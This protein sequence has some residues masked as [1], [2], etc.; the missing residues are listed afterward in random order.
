MQSGLKHGYTRLFPTFI[1]LHNLDVFCNWH[2]S[3][4]IR[5][6]R[7]VLTGRWWAR[8][9]DSQLYR[10]ALMRQKLLK[11]MQRQKVCSA[12]ALHRCL[13]EHSHTNDEYYRTLHKDAI[14]SWKVCC[15]G[16]KGATCVD[17][18]LGP[19]A[20]QK[21]T[22]SNTMFSFLVVTSAMNLQRQKSFEGNIIL[23][24]WHFQF[25]YCENLV[26]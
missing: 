6:G 26:N 9:V 15:S 22:S 12:V 19:A 24:W 23:S 1:L 20:L 13:C 7:K 4:V 11:R 14:M 2:K 3:C 25:I 8:Q 10:A 21:V 5:K 16:P 18:F 17:T